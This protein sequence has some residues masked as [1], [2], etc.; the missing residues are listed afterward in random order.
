MNPF[1]VIKAQLSTLVPF[2]NFVGIELI[3]L[4][5]G[6]ASARMEQRQDTS[7]HIQS[8]HAGAMFTLGEAAS[9]AA[10]AASM[11]PVI[12]SVR[13]VAASATINFLKIAK[14]TLTAF[15]KTSAPGAELLAT[16]ESEGKVAFEVVVDI[17]D[18]EKDSVV[19]M[20]ITWHVSKRS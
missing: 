5:D 11:A 17:Q 18:S 10:M 4:S 13:P 2:Q 14:G 1:E 15:A 20:K 19:E 8:Q 12:L 16:L 9:G 6:A 3:E 7:N